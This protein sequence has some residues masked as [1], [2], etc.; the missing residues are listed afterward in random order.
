MEAELSRLTEENQKLTKM[1][2]VMCE[3]FQAL[4]NQVRD[5]T[6]AGVVEQVHTSPRKRK[7]D[8]VSNVE[9]SSSEDSSKKQCKFPKSKT[10]KVSVR[11]DPSDT[12]LVN[13]YPYTI[14]VFGRITRID[15]NEYIF[16]IEFMISWL[17]MDT[18]GE[19][20]AKR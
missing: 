14:R 5:L 16:K 7:D 4:Q 19:N 15:T 2:A 10:S 8:A 6:S 20:M 18:N 12:S 13:I 17:K 9:C 1:L 11:T 3:N